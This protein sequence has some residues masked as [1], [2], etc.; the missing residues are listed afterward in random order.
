MVDQALT[1]DA[2]YVNEQ[3]GELSLDEDLS[4]YIL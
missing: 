4:Q 3:L 1:I 2:D